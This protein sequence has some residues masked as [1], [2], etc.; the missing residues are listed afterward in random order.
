[1]RKLRDCYLFALAVVLLVGAWLWW[2]RAGERVLP[3]SEIMPCEEHVTVNDDNDVI[4]VGTDSKALVTEY[5]AWL[6]GRKEKG[7]EIPTRRK[8]R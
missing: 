6:V 1:M 4:F 7:A 3:Y 2:C 8:V 5:S